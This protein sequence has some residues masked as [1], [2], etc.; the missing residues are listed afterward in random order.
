MAATPDHTPSPTIRRILVPLDG[1]DTSRAA[2]AYARQFTDATIVLLQVGIDLTSIFPDFPAA[3][4]DAVDTDIRNDLEAFAVPLRDE[5]LTVETI[6]EDGDPAE[7]IV[8]T[9]RR[10]AADLIVM[11]TH[12]RGAAGRVLFGSV[13]DRVSRHAPMPTLLV[14]IGHEREV[15]PPTRILVTLDG[16]ARSETAL[17]LAARLGRSLGLPIVLTRVVTLEDTLGQAPRT[18]QR[19]PGRPLD[20][21]DEAFAIAQKEIELQAV[22]Y[23]ERLAGTVAGK[24][25]TFVLHGSPAIALLQELGPSDLAVITSHGTSGIS[26]WLLG[27]VAEKLVREAAAPVVLVPARNQESRSTEDL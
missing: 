8:T 25:S 23:L 5:G 14:R 4:S 15:Q 1:S 16:S 3:E 21:T 19:L 7:R 17:P 6:V 2:L 20:T 26:R 27:S 24:V 10:T 12:G 18:Q 13:A 11:T 9:A 22:A